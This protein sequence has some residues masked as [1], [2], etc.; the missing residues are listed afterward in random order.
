MSATLETAETKVVSEPDVYQR[1]RQQMDGVSYFR[2]LM[3]RESDASALVRLDR[4]AR[5]MELERRVNPNLT[6][7]QGGYFAPPGWLIDQFAHL[8]RA[9][10]PLADRIDKA[11]NRFPLPQGVQSINIPR[12]TSGTAEGPQDDGSSAASG[13]VVDTQTN[14]PVVT[15]A[16]NSDVSMQ[17]LEQSPVGAH[18]DAMFFQDLVS[19]YDLALSQ[20]LLYG[21]GPTTQPTQQLQG[22]MTISGTNGVTF[23][24]ASP[25]A[26]G[27]FTY[28]GQAISKVGNNRKRPPELWLMNTSRAGWLGSS[29][30][31]QNRPLMIADNVAITGEFDLLGFPVIMDDVIPNTLTGNPG[32][33][34]FGSAVNQDV[35]IACRPSDMLLFESTP[36]MSVQTEV[37]SGTLQA[38]LQYRC[39]A[40]F[41]CRYPS[42]VAIMSGTGNVVQAGFTS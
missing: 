15:I 23:T 31:T 18:L 19:A 41:I 34:T 9:G 37:L 13:D 17:L 35:I 27:M 28:L 33:L 12:M 29:E 5:Q 14:C 20:Q 21:A 10:R 24:S 1:D 32:S 40:A 16:G 36:V 30:D 3:F 2:D 22:L 6:Q 38:R 39:Y 26:T 25:S 42:G 8:P 7:G 11:K 4:H